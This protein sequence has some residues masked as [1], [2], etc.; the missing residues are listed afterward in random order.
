MSQQRHD[1][2]SAL[3]CSEVELAA[4]LARLVELG[5]IR[6]WGE[7]RGAARHPVRRRLRRRAPTRP[8]RPSRCGSRERDIM[9]VGRARIDDR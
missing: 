3:A 4:D 2:A 7:R 8:G 9:T 5:L 1:P 6:L